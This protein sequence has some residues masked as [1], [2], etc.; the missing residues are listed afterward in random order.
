MSH[1]WKSDWQERNETRRVIENL[2]DDIRQIR[3]Q[4]DS[5]DDADKLMDMEAEIAAIEDR[6]D[7]LEQD[8]R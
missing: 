6:I 5:I 2:R 8:L 3:R 7:D 1:I 4:M